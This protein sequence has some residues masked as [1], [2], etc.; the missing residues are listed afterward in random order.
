MKICK[1]CKIRKDYTDFPSSGK[2]NT[3][4]AC[5]QCYSILQNIKMKYRK[6]YSNNKKV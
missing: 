6:I 5:K 2:G 4:N 3:R 1:V